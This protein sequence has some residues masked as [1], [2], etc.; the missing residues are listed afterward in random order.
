MFQEEMDDIDFFLFR[1]EAHA[2]AFKWS[3][4]IWPLQLGM[5][6][7]VSQL[8]DD[9]TSSFYSPTPTDHSAEIL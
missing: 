9:V 4:E 3:R 6:T 5:S 8:V 7:Q 1:F 2:Q